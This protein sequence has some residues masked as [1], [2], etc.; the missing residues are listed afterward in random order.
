MLESRSWVLLRRCYRL[1]GVVIVWLG[2]AAVLSVDPISKLGAGPWSFHA[3]HAMHEAVFE[4]TFVYL[5]VWKSEFSVPAHEIVVEL[6]CVYRTVSKGHPACPMH[7]PLVKVAGV[8]VTIIVLHRSRPRHEPIFV[9]FTV[10]HI[11]VR[12]LERAALSHSPL[13]VTAKLSTIGVK[14][15]PSAFEAVLEGACVRVSG[16][17]PVL[18]LYLRTVAELPIKLTA[19]RV[20]VQASPVHEPIVPSAVVDF[21]IAKL[22]YALALLGAVFPLA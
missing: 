12:E 15:H 7:Q 1:L 10:V 13:K 19:I 22:E 11:A 2:E 14:H 6:A 16:C 3:P 9:V 21:T 8:A 5:P 17:V 20:R 4:L 18:A